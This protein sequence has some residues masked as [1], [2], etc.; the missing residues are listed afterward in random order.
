MPRNDILDAAVQIF[1]QKGFH[2]ASMQDIAVAVN[3][4]KGS[5]YHY[6]SS[7]QEILVEVLDQSI[8]FLTDNMESVM[9]L[10][11]PANEKLRLAMRVYL[12]EMLENQD[13]ASVLLLEH[14]SLE[15]EYR[16]RHIPL[17]DKFERLWQEL[18]NEGVSQS[19]FNCEDPAITA[20]AILGVMNWAVTWYRPDGSLN[21]GEIAEQFADLFLGGLYA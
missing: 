10:D 1:G 11:L 14:R 12:Q 21:P 3:L 16:A 4:Q 18:I 17:R 15:P 7:K 13:K 8:K 9:Q 19:L 6:V 20:R 5:L 2:A